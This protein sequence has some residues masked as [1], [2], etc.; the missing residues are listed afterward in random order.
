MIHKTINGWTKEKMKAQIRAKNDGSK[1]GSYE[2]GFGDFACKYRGDNSNACA[3][4]CFILDEDYKSE[5]EGH[6]LQGLLEYEEFAQ[7]P[8]DY[9]GLKE[10]QNEHDSAIKMPPDGNMRDLLCNWIDN[11]V[12]D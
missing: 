7:M 12:L 5:F 4:G 3:V 2:I 9:F 8:L 10:M 11:N 1:S 6:S